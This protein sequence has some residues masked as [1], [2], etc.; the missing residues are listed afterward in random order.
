MCCGLCARALDRLAHLAGDLRR[1]GRAGAQDDQTP[2]GTLLRHEYNSFMAPLPAV[3]SARPD[4][5]VFA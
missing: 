5:P 1:I 3:P 2:E 4:A